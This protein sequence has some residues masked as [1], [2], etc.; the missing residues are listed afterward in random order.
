MLIPARGRPRPRR[1]GM[2]ATEARYAAHLALL[3]G[4]GEVAWY[5]F[6]PIKL[7]LADRTWYEPDFLVML[8]GGE[9]ECHEVKGFWEDDARVKIKVAA[10]TYPMRFVAVRATKGG[11]EVERFL[12]AQEKKP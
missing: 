5:A 2:N 1:S 12:E 9:L 10:E 8:A 4:A 3:A 11:W 7:R 6:Q